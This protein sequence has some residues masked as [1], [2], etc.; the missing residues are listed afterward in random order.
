MLR[1]G[2]S[3]NWA[4]DDAASDAAS[5][6]GRIDL[7][8]VSEVYETARYTLTRG[9]MIVVPLFDLKFLEEFAAGDVEAANRR[10]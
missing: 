2:S 9:T 4:A 6:M 1:A 5:D 3:M 7:G 8:H 10:P